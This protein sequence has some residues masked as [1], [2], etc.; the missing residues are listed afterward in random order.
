[1]GLHGDKRNE[2]L[3]GR[4]SEAGDR[5][6]DMG[7]TDLSEKRVPY[8]STCMPTLPASKVGYSST[9]ERALSIKYV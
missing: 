1:M 2:T 4:G 9:T 3:Q 7:F 5:G 8:I 6:G